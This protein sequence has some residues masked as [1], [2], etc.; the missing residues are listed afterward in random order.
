MHTNSTRAFVDTCGETD[1]RHLRPIIA[2]KNAENVQMH[3]F[4]QHFNK[5]HRKSCSTD[6]WQLENLT[7]SVSNLGLHEYLQEHDSMIIQ[8]MPSTLK[9]A[10]FGESTTNSELILRLPNLATSLKFRRT[11]LHFD[12]TLQLPPSLKFLLIVQPNIEMSIQF[13]KLMTQLEVPW[14]ILPDNAPVLPPGLINLSIARNGSP[15]CWIQDSSSCSERTAHE[16]SP[17]FLEAGRG[18]CPILN[19]NT[20]LDLPPSLEQLLIRN[21][22]LKRDLLLNWWMMMPRN[23]PLRRLHSSPGATAQV[24]Q[25]ANIF[26]QL[27]NL[28]PLQWIG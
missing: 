11:S 23:L 19:P 25:R 20:A 12:S 28:S 27:C 21:E 26:T 24:H 2:S 4:R 10:G 17:Q 8:H 18:S 16:R 3:P 14:P 15:V 13:P 6:R 9:F 1:T 5:F 22:Y 7:L